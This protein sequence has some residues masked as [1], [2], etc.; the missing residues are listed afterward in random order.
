MTTTL[1]VLGTRDIN[2]RRYT[3]GEELPPDLL[4][5]DVV[6]KWLDNRWLFEYYSADRRSL[7]RLFA[8]FSGSKEQGQLTKEELTAYAL[9]P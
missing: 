2:G 3:Q 9:P 5:R 4:P 8:P 7:F 1:V 6:D